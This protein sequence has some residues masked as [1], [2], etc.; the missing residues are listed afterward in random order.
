MR[1]RGFL[2]MLAGGL[3]AAT[4]PERLLWVPG[5]R[6]ISIPR[7]RGNEFLTSRMITE[8]CLRILRRNTALI[9]RIGDTVTV[10]RPRLFR[11]VH[12]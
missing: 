7:P 5:Q 1:R 6:L 2:G 3:F 4:D 10:R 11:A 8:E 12:G 9:P